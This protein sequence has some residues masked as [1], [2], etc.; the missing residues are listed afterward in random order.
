MG[1]HEI[2]RE[3]IWDALKPYVENTEEIE[4]VADKIMDVI[5]ENYRSITEIH[6]I[7]NEVR[8]G[9]RVQIAYFDPEEDDFTNEMV[10]RACW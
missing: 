7:V 3:V 1:E 2:V 5:S 6:Y 4:Q 8:A 9:G 10:V